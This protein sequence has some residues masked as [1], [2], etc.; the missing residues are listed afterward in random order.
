MVPTCADKLGD[1]TVAGYAAVWYLLDGAVDGGE[2]YLGF[3][4]AGHGSGGTRRR[5]KES[6][7][8]ESNHMHGMALS[9][10]RSGL[11]RHSRVV[12]AVERERL[13]AK[14][15]ASRHC[16][17]LTIEAAYCCL[18]GQYGRCMSLTNLA[19]LNS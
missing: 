2:E 7:G 14:A 16:L 9:P 10:Y 11:R 18:S 17:R 19:T 5:G 4:G 8:P 12:V 6:S 15:R 13:S 3:V 1:V